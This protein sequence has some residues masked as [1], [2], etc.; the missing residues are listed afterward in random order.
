MLERQA[1]GHMTTLM[2]DT[3]SDIISPQFKKRS[4]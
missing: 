2:Q 1:P 3:L 4:V